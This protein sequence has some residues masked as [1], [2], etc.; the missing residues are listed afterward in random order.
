MGLKE[1]ETREEFMERLEAKLA[2]CQKKKQP[3]SRNGRKRMSARR[4]R[5]GQ[6]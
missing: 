5:K 2:K 6:Y 4:K 3:S 1:G